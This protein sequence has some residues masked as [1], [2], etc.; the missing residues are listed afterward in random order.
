MAQ[1]TF[2]QIREEAKKA[3]GYGNHPAGTFTM[4]ISEATVRRGSNQQPQ[5]QARYK[6]IDQGPDLGKSLLNNMSPEK[7]DGD[8]NPMFFQ[9]MAAFGFP[10][11][12]ALWAQI[13]TME[14]DQAVAL[15][16]S[17]IL[18]A[19]AI[20]IIEHAQYKDE[21]RDNVK[22]VK[23]LGS[24]VPTGAIAT[25]TGV[26]VAAAPGVPPVA[27]QAPVA[28]VPPAAPPVAPVAPAAAP[29]VAPVAPVAAPPQ[30]QAVVQ[31]A[32]PQAQPVVEAAPQPVPQAAPAQVPAA[33]PATLPVQAP[34][35]TQTP[36]PEPAQEATPGPDSI[37]GVV[38]QLPTPAAPEPAQLPTPPQ[39]RPF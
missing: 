34:N 31:A 4:E 15:I 16:A 7:N 33:E 14:A 20:V 13:D 9:Q 32:P 6:T 26:P 28:P 1:R 19:Q 3:P 5:I 22:R 37:A 10:D 39:D 21:I 23:P 8:P 38:A 25:P 12:H 2:G 17:T 27:P 29:P 36:T 30:P 18:G 11:E 24:I 35:L